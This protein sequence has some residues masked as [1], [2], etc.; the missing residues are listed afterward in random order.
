M[1][2]VIYYFSSFIHI[3]HQYIIQFNQWFVKYI[4]SEQ[5]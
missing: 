3:H 1:F 5:M 2:H 4:S